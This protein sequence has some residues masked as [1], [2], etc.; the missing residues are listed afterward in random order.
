MSSCA[1]FLSRELVPEDRS[2]LRESNT[3]TCV[4][5]GRLLYDVSALVGV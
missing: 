3:V 5:V 4:T 2:V 1:F